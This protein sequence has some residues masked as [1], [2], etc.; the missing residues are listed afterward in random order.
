MYYQHINQ[1]VNQFFK[2]LQ[3]LEVL[4]VPKVSKV[5]A[6][7]FF[8]KNWNLEVLEVPEVPD[9]FSKYKSIYETIFQKAS[10]LEVLE[11]PEV[12]KVPANKNSF[13][14]NWKPIGSRGSRGSGCIINI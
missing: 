14:K 13:S 6:N 8:S 2:E 10:K 11:F 5:P 12:P 3:N 7:N 1:Y 9:V 4:E